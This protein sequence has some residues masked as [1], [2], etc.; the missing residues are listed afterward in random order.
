MSGSSRDIRL[1]NAPGVTHRSYFLALADAICAG[2]DAHRVLLGLSAEE[3]DFVR[4]NHGLVRQATCVTQGVARVTVVRGARQAQGS[5]T[6]RGHLHADVTL[7]LELRREL[8][9]DLADLP[10]D[11]YLLLPDTITSTD[12][13]EA[14]QLP[15]A[16][17]LIAIVTEHAHA[18]DFVGFYAG[19]PVV[20]AF[21][22]SRGQRNWHRVESFHFSWCLYHHA[23]KAVRTAYAGTRWD[24]TAFLD[25]L[26]TATSRVPLLGLP[27]HALAP[28]EY[29]AWL[30]PDAM[31]ELLTVMAW[32][33]F[34]L[35]DRR[36]GVSTLG[37]L[38]RGEARLDPRF[39]LREAT[40]RG[41]AP[42]FT[43]T[44]FAR[45]AEVPL[46][47][48]GRVVDA[49]ASPRTAREYGVPTNGAEGDESPQ[50]A[51]LAA[52]TLAE[53]DVL[54]ALGTGLWISNL[55]YLNYSDREA[56]RVTGMTRFACFWVEDGQLKAPL[57]VMRFDDSLLRV[58]GEG[59]EALGQRAELLPDSGTWGERRLAS[60]TTPG[61]LV[62]GFR[63]TL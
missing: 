9:A 61:A 40:S 52:G 15:T 18:L 41:T 20:R 57:D 36:T 28:G 2:T 32:G 56:A 42:S 55:W 16:E 26:Q 23:D 62:R 25:R 1:D 63:L 5:A 48:E 7:L 44:G 14:G 53:A 10:D 38:A 50:S 17:R 8:L 39:N 51:H 30:T 11:P 34:G 4:F 3:S 54:P 22:D 58:F 13:E 21:A 60:T 19:G 6:V 29:R 12:R 27:R 33:G 45:P 46:L 31:N 59:L 24:D 49:L 37:R 35:K 47:I 43:E